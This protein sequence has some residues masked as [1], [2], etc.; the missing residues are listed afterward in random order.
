MSEPKRGGALRSPRSA[1]SAVRALARPG[2][3][4]APAANT[5]ASPVSGGST[6][7]RSLA[8]AMKSVRLASSL[9]NGSGSRSPVSVR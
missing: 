2:H 5:P 1:A 7:A 4:R 6:F 8:A 9:T 3:P